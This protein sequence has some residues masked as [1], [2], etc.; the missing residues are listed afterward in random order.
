MEARDFVQDT[1]SLQ[2][3]DVAETAWPALPQKPELLQWLE[4]FLQT[5]AEKN[6]SGR[7]QDTV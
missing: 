3:L 2:C 4:S 6:L 7:N 5:Q 1:S